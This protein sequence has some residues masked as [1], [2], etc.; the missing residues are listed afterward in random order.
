M[1]RLQERADELERRARHRHWYAN[2]LV[3]EG[4]YELADKARKG[5]CFLGKKEHETRK[6]IRHRRMS[7]T[8][9]GG[10]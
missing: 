8:G 1:T 10:K 9:A 7:A 5:A 4:H 3:A 2:A 6:R